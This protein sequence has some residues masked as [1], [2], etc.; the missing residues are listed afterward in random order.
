MPL[1]SEKEETKSIQEGL[2]E[3]SELQRN[4][5]LNLIEFGADIQNNFQ[6]I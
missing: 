5:N 1:G 3:P 4:C 2:K 6:F